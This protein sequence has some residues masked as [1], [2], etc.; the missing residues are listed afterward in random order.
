MASS[1]SGPMRQ[2]FCARSMCVSHTQERRFYSIFV[3]KRFHVRFV[4]FFLL[5]SFHTLCC[6]PFEDKCVQMFLLQHCWSCQHFWKMLH[7]TS[8]C[9]SLLCWLLLPDFAVLQQKDLTR[10]RIAMKT[11]KDK[12]Q[13]S[14]SS[15]ARSLSQIWGKENRPSLMPHCGNLHEI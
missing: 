5:S 3:L 8:L 12:A 1:C 4:C 15:I 10:G 13:W 11:L 7:T 9:F 6:F 2:T 14:C